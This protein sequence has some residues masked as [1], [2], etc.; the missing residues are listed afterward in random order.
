MFL[1]GASTLFHVLSHSGWPQGYF[2][3]RFFLKMKVFIVKMRHSAEGMFRITNTKRLPFLHNGLIHLTILSRWIWLHS[4]VFSGCRMTYPSDYFYV[5]L[6]YL[7]V[8]SIFSLY[9]L[10]SRLECSYLSDDQYPITRVSA[11]PQGNRHRANLHLQWTHLEFN[12]LPIG[13]NLKSRSRH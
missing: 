6:C 4:H 9:V 10:L 12:D 11:I 7:A 5:R 8:W 13:G 2:Y 3:V 1:L